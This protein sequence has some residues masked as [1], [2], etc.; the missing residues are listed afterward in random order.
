MDFK[1]PNGP[2]ELGSAKP[3]RTKGHTR[4]RASDGADS[5]DDKGPGR[6]SGEGTGSILPHLAHAK[7]TVPAIPFEV[8]AR[9]AEID[10]EIA[11]HLLKLVELEHGEPEERGDPKRRAILQESLAAL[12]AERRALLSE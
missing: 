6:R 12:A 8:S 11:G 10:I 4:A 7:S 1:N 9:V 3:S 2:R 5:P